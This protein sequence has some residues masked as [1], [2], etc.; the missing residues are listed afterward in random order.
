MKTFARGIAALVTATLATLAT[1][2]APGEARADATCTPTVT[3]YVSYLNQ[4]GGWFNFELSIH[5][6]DAPLV[7]YSRGQISKWGNSYWPLRGTSSQLFSDRFSYA[8]ATP[9]PFQV[10]A[11][12]QLTV[13][14]STSGELYIHYAPWNFTTQ[15]DLSCSGNVFTKLVPGYG[16]VT[17]TLRN[18]ETIY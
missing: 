8:G 3:N 1:L 5:R 17:L 6:I 7:T 12:D 18:W 15:W 4:H 2:A 14:V 11:A 16:V 9:Q 13:Y 10:G